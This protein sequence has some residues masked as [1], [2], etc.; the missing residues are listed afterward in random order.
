MATPHPNSL[1]EGP[2]KV[3]MLT[4]LSKNRGPVLQDCVASTKFVVMQT[5]SEQ[6][7]RRETDQKLQ[8]GDGRLHVNGHWSH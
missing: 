1:D 8:P 5:Y 2:S 4:I 7:W 6:L 3:A